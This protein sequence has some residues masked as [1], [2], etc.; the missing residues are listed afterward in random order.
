MLILEIVTMAWRAL[1]TNKLR[2]TLTTSGITIGIF[3]VISVITTISALQSSIETGLTSLG[4]NIFQFSKWP[5][6]DFHTF[7]NDRFKNR[8]NIDYAT[9]L[10]FARLMKDTVDL[11]V[12]NVLENNVQS[13]YENKK[14]NPN[15]TLGGT[16]QGFIIS[17][18]FKIASGRNL[19]PE[20]VEYSRSVCVVGDEV[21]TRLFAE[22]G[23]VGR[24]IRLDNRAYEVIGTFAAKGGSFGG[25][26]DKMVIIP[27]TKFFENY[28]SHNRSIDVA[29]QSRNQL[30]YERTM[31]FATAAFRRAR[32]LKPEDSNDFETYGNDSLAAAF[33]NIAGVV[34]VGAFVISTT[35]LVAAGIGI[36]NIMLVS[37]T[38]RTKEIGIRKSL[39]ARQRDILWQFLLEAL[40]LSLLGAITGIV[41]GVLAGNALAVFLRAKVGIPWDWALAGVLVCSVIGIV[42][43]LYPARKAA[44][45]DPIEALRFE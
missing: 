20:D 19:S 8:R 35:A 29:V 32:G 41:L 42:F 18:D 34:W 28:G 38:E 27:I 11:T 39:G 37:V 31:G 6:A 44:S 33:R 2:S 21:V 45:L 25:S 22:G 36:M 9:Y 10:E 17:N 12:P 40:F 5:A 7:G 26:D 14:T 24:T 13:V 3:S 30:V 16:T 23:A 4:S 1:G 43:G 15:L